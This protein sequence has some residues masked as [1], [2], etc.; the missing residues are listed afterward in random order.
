MS[1]NNFNSLKFEDLVQQI[2]SAK[3]GK[4]QDFESDEYFEPEIKY[5]R[6]GHRK[7]TLLTD[8]IITKQSI[9]TE[10]LSFQFRK[11][12]V[13]KN[14][15]KTVK[16]PHKEKVIVEA[17]L[18]KQNNITEVIKTE[19]K[20]KP[21]TKS[22][23]PID[24]ESN[25]N[26]TRSLISSPR[27]IVK[28]PKNGINDI[29]GKFNKHPCLAFVQQIIRKESKPAD[30]VQVSRLYTILRLYEFITTLFTFIGKISLSF[31]F[32]FFYY[33]L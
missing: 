17:C 14:I 11:Q 5:Q 25:L 6:N 21:E 13:L 19:L 12:N 4:K 23:S 31:S 30:Q 10:T 3:R 7:T 33:L 20:N 15:S 18:T 2:V 28:R 26:T 24:T 22:K 16:A 32:Y 9:N 27:N 1:N 8:L 29:M